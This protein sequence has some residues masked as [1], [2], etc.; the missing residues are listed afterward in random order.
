MAKSSVS[1]TLFH[2]FVQFGCVQVLYIQHT[3]TPIYIYIYIYIYSLKCSNI[4]NIY[5]KGSCVF[6]TFTPCASFRI[7]FIVYNIWWYINLYDKKENIECGVEHYLY[8]KQCGNFVFNSCIYLDCVALKRDYLCLAN[9]QSCFFWSN[10]LNWCT[11]L[12]KI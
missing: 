4:L 7:L 5:R 6:V 9:I 10:L 11:K 12:K 8:H 1:Q 2:R 3:H